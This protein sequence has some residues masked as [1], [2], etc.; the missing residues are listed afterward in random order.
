MRGGSEKSNEEPC[1]YVVFLNST[2][3][4]LL[5]L[6]GITI[7]V[8]CMKLFTARSLVIEIPSLLKFNYSSMQVRKRQYASS[9]IIESN[10]FFR[11][12]W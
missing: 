7:N 4:L 10:I 8:L 6:C 12:A 1:S 3:E 9:L 5:F 2:A 11:N